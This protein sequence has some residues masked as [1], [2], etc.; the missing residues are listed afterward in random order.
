[1][2]ASLP[3][4]VAPA[5]IRATPRPPRLTPTA[6][7]RWRHRTMPAIPKNTAP[8]SRPKSRNCRSEGGRFG[9]RWLIE[10]SSVELELLLPRLSVFRPLALRRFAQQVW[11]EH[12][13]IDV[14]PHE[15]A[16]RVFRRTHD[17]LAADVER[18]VHDH[19]TSGQRLERA[20]QGMVIGIRLF[21][22]SLQTGRIVDVRDRGNVRAHDVELGDTPQRLVLFSGHRDL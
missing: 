11:T 22:H 18:R 16:I 20:D 7:L 5:S 17:R 6:K 1:M 3:A 13:I 4:A 15:A 2:R 8:T 10:S 19:R 14:G 12:E 21:A 9:S